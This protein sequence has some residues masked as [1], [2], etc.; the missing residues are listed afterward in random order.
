MALNVKKLRAE[1]QQKMASNTGATIVIALVFFL[2][3]AVTGVTVLTAGTAAS[4]RLSGLAA[5]EQE[6]YSV[7]SAAETVEQMIKGQRFAAYQEKEGGVPLMGENVIYT[8]KPGGELGA[9]L[10]DAVAAIYEKGREGYEETFTLA[11]TGEEEKTEITGRLSMSEDYSVTVTL[12]SA[13][14]DKY[15]CRV[16]AG[17]LV[18]H[19][20]DVFERK[21]AA[22]K[23]VAVAREDIAVTWDKC[24]VSKI[25]EEVQF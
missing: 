2:L 9:M 11:L 3:C 17:S 19:R 13:A 10:T 1:V 20:A 5:A 22:G 12:K 6:Y 23:V 14:S 18:D 24:S 8:Q 25:G 4:G 21:N 7:T 16:S 15:V